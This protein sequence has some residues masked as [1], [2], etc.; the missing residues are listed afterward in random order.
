[1]HRPLLACTLLALC[2]ASVVRAGTPDD[3]HARIDQHLQRFQLTE[4]VIAAP[5]SSDAEFLRRVT[6][7]LIGRIPTVSEVRAFLSDESSEKRARRV[8]EL[9]ASEEH[10]E[11]F[12]RVWRAL[13][14]PEADSDRQLAFFVPGLEAW[15]REARRKNLPFSQL[16]REI[17]AAPILGTPE[18]PQFVLTDLNAPNPIAFIASKDDDPAKIAA[19]SLRLFTG[20]RLECAQCHDHPFDHFTREQFWN[21][22]AFFAGIARRG[23]G[24]FS[25]VMEDRAKRT[26]SIPTTQITVPLR[27]LSGDTPDIPLEVSP[28]VTFADWLTASSNDAFHR[29]TVNRIWAQMMGRGLVDPIDDF[30]AANPTLHPDLLTELATAFQQS[31]CDL[32]ALYREICLSEAYQRSSRQTDGSQADGQAFAKMAIKAMSA[33]QLYDSLR[34]ATGMDGGAGGDGTQMMAVSRRGDD[35]SRRRFLDQ[36]A[37]NESFDPQT[38]VPQALSLMN[39]GLINRITSQSGRGGLNRSLNASSHD[40]EA[41]ADELVLAAW[42]R[43]PT[44]EEREVLS[45]FLSREGSLEAATADVQWML[46]NSPE[47]RWNH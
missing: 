36:F 6:L 33:E 27:L 2:L 32:T 42:G 41:A 23:K 37:A 35:R 11:H 45:R 17:V 8:D 18:Q 43:L 38:A 44:T 20:Q 12:A 13:L 24:A 40:S 15:L 46:L 26:A 22:A 29:A 4:R 28:R 47:F 19:I 10:A 34:V 14:L 9:L 1:M 16:V 25:P 21:Q 7:D 5:L 3:L 31:G 30:S 39:G